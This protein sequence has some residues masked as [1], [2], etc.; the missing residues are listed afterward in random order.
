LRFF[1]FFSIWGWRAQAC[2]QQ[3]A[4]SFPSGNS[5]FIHN[6]PL[7]FFPDV[8]FSFPLSRASPPKVF[9]CD[10][11]SCMRGDNP[12]PLPRMAFSRAAQLFFPPTGIFFSVRCPQTASDSFHH[13]DA[14]FFLKCSPPVDAEVLNEPPHYFRENSCHFY[15]RSFLSLVQPRP[16]VRFPSP[17][18][19]FLLSPL[20]CVVSLFLSTDGTYLFAPFLLYIGKRGPHLPFKI[21]P[22][23]GGGGGVLG[24]FVFGGFETFRLSSSGPLWLS[25]FFGVRMCLCSFFLTGGPLPTFLKVLLGSLL[26]E[27]WSE[28]CFLRMQARVPCDGGKLSSTE[29]RFFPH[30]GLMHFPFLFR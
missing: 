9:R 12:P 24:V 16:R 27:A 6:F 3:A 19:F 2:F 10:Q 21:S 25:I 13:A 4:W 26:P 7:R 20:C 15:A 17:L 22:W 14:V 1:F 5:N 30:T 18:F 23:F 29:H 28:G 8:P 11:P